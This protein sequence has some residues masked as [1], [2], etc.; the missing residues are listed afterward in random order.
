MDTTNTILLADDEE[1]NLGLLTELCR[2]LG[3]RC[4]T[5]RNG[6]ELVDLA[7]EQHPDL[8]I[9]DVLMPE[10]DG[11]AA[12]E[13]IKSDPRTSGIPVIIVTAKDSRADRLTGISKGACDFLT[14]PFDIQELSLRVESRLK[15]KKYQDLLKDNAAL[16]EN[17]VAER[18][19]EPF[20][21]AT[22]N[23]RTHASAGEPGGRA[24]RRAEASD[25][26]T[27]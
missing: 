1:I 18:T 2:H 7:R 8:I 13:A 17:Q 5:A 6:R 26:Q 22:P 27:G 14:K 15:L 9:T 12:T 19:G 23:F 10:L 16:L 20:L 3:Y 4:L 24:H 11:F 25:G 21:I